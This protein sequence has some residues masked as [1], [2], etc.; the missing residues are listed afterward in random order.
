MDKL[1]MEGWTFS[2]I[3]WINY[4]SDNYNQHKDKWIQLSFNN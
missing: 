4:K 1:I 3:M 2:Y